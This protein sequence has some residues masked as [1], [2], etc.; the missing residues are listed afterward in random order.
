MLKK[1]TGRIPTRNDPANRL[2]RNAA[3]EALYR[4]ELQVSVGI[5]DILPPHWEAKTPMQTAALHSRADIL[6]FGGSRW[7]A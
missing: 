3:E 6:F 4:E 1:A 2:E 5:K 7:F